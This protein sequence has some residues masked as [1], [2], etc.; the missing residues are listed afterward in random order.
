[1]KRKEAS[2]F[3]SPQVQPLLLT[4]LS[5]VLLTFFIFLGSHAQESWQQAERVMA[6]VRTAFGGRDLPADAA[7]STFELP[8][9]QIFATGDDQVLAAALTRLNRIAE[10]AKSAQVMITIEE[11]CVNGAEQWAECQLL[12]MRRAGALYRFF[13]DTGGSSQEPLARGGTS[14]R[15]RIL[16]QLPG[17][18]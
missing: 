1:V 17:A 2:T 6:G 16:I 13:R 10:G 18:R 5:L 3:S 4:S 14:D 8:S 9:A 15:G 12:A 7:S 11:P